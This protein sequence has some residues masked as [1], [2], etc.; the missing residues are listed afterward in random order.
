MD[1]GK[2]IHIGL[3]SSYSANRPHFDV[4]QG[5]VPQDV[6]L[7]IEGLDLRRDLPREGR[8]EDVVRRAAEMVRRTRVHGLIVPGAP[9]AIANPEVETRLAEELK[10]PVSTAVHATTAALRSI[11]AQRLILMTPFD[12]E[13]N[14][15]L[16]NL[17]KSCGFAVL[18][19]PSLGHLRAISD[20]PV[21]PEEI[22]RI[23]ETTVSQTRGADTIYFQ[24]APF[25]PLPVI[26]RIETRLGLPVVAS[27]PAMLWHLLS[28]LERKYSISGYGK[29]LASWPALT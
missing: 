28:L 15:R 2:Q 16:G 9:L 27:S 21:E 24:G 4:L 23:V 20:A 26:E 6:A 29:L 1:A 12:D 3:L 5:L 10:I 14:L 13:T 18:S 19:C 11:G 7:T 8:A 25:D 22:F 17:L